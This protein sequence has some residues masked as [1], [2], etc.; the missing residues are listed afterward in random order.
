M[1]SRA[2]IEQ[3]KGILMA[4]AGLSADAAFEQLVKQSQHENVKVRDLA[5]EIVRRSQRNRRP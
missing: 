4:T 3:A 1:Q 2:E 5:A